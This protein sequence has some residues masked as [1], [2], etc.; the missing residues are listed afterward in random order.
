M[1]QSA[2]QDKVD[3]NGVSYENYP[4]CPTCGDNGAVTRFKESELS[5]GIQEREEEKFSPT[6]VCLRCGSPL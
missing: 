1:S 3:A 5:F 6:W 2:D 4:V